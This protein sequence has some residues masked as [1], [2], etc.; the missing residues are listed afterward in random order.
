MTNPKERAVAITIDDGQLLV[1]LRRKDGRSYAVLPGGGIEPGESPREAVVRELRE[2][3]HLEGHI[4]R[5]LWTIRHQDRRAHYFLVSVE[6]SRLVLGD[7]EASS[8]SSSNVYQPTWVDTARV[9]D[10]NL[11]PEELRSRLRE[12]L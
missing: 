6:R 10:I 4:E 12:L 1:I 7:P 2:E 8:Q 5:E 3:T 11:Q 9:D